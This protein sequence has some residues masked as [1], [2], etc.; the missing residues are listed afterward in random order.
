MMKLVDT[1]ETVVLVTGTALTAEERDRP[2]AYWLKQ[3][4]D[5][6]GVGYPYRR[7]VV[8]GDV[9][10][11]ENR[12]FHL[13]PT[14]AIGGPGANAL[15]HEMVESLPTRWTQDDESLIQADFD[16]ELKRATLWGMNA[17]T[18][19]AAVEAFVVKG[20]L[21]ELLEKIWR[22]RTGVYV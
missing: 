13:N 7:A 1:E 21:D 6:R 22:F 20:F 14:I 3:E 16:G 4:I 8:V 19:G 18:T 10:Y 12:V 2:L 5:K 9:W 17:A 15:T 11:L